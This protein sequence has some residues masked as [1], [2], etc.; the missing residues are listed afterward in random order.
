VQREIVGRAW[1]DDGATD[2]AGGG[3][4][5]ADAEA[6]RHGRAGRDAGRQFLARQPRH[7]R[8]VVRAAEAGARA[9]GLAARAAP[10]PRPP[11]IAAAAPNQPNPSET[12]GQKKRA[13][14]ARAT[15]AKRGGAG[16]ARLPAAAV[17]MPTASRSTEDGWLVCACMGDD[18]I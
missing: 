10:A 1:S 2:A 12:F 18:M 9:P 13:S 7:G 11:A 6:R 16:G 3:G 17:P 4:D 5:A 15:G 8:R 14:R